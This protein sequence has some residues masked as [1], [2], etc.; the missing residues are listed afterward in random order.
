[1]DKKFRSALLE[2]DV[3]R[4]LRIDGH[5]V[6]VSADRRQ[7]FV[8]LQAGRRVQLVF[9]DPSRNFRVDGVAGARYVPLSGADEGACGFSFDVSGLRKVVLQTLPEHLVIYVFPQSA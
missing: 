9:L 5:N 4:I 3:L 1:M 7:D 6:L 2:G 8:E